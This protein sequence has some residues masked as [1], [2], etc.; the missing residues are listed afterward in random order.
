MNNCIHLFKMNSRKQ[1]E[2]LMTA[3]IFSFSL[4]YFIINFVFVYCKIL[5]QQHQQLES[6]TI[7][8]N[9]TYS[10]FWC[11]LNLASKVGLLDLAILPFLPN[12][13]YYICFYKYFSLSKAII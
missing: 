7:S 6:N 2:L 10:T 5:I 11:A 8:I 4:V 13:N 9:P 1:R 3:Y 12:S